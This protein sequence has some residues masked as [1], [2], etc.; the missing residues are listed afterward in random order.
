MSKIEDKL[1]D[2]LAETKFNNFLKKKEVEEKKKIKVKLQGWSSLN[3]LSSG[4]DSKQND[5]NN[6]N[7]GNGNSN[8]GAGQDNGSDGYNSDDGGFGGFF[9][10]FGY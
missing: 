1:E 8:N 6:G 3:G 4:D 2:L 7:S 9:S 5:S 10:P